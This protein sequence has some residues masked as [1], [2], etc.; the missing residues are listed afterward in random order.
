MINMGNTKYWILTLLYASLIFFLSSRPV[1]PE[2]P[3]VFL[4]DKFL[5]AIEYG[6]LGFLI[7]L[8]LHKSPERQRTILLATALSI[9]YGIGEEL[10]QYFVPF[11]TADPFDVL[12]DGIGALIGGWVEVKWQNIK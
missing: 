8:S 4:M 12:A 9:L 10:H 2:A 7:A 5:H 11:R 6:V 3:Q 1:P